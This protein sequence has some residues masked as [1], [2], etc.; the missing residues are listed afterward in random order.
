[1][2]ELARACSDRHAVRRISN[3]IGTQE[4]SIDPIVKPAITS[5][6]YHLSIADGLPSK[7]DAR[8][9]VIYGAAVLRSND[10]DWV[11]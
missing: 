10:P 8:R 9:K 3:E 7:A 1:L 4:V 2:E 11:I 6:H 5:A